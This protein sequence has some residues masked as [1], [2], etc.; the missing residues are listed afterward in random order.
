MGLVLIAPTEDITLQVFTLPPLHQRLS[1]KP[2]Q[3]T[4][5]DG[6][7][8]QN[9]SLISNGT[10]IQMPFFSDDNTAQ[11]VLRVYIFKMFAFLLNEL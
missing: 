6:S 1:F 7:H 9:P 11:E 8:H 3:S 5:K 4:K 10:S 2:N